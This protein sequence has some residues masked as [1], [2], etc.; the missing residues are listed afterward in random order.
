MSK[1]I[2]G[3]LSVATMVWSLFAVCANAHISLLSTR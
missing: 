1:K 3:I 2:A